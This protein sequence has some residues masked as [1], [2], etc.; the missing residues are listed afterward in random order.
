MSKANFTGMEDIQTLFRETIA[1]FMEDSLDVEPE[2]T[3]GYGKY[4]HTAGTKRGN[5]RH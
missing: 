3:L 1:E 2:K 4:Y 5:L